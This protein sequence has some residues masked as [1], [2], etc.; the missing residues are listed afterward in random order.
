M[1]KGVQRVCWFAV[2]DQ[3]FPLS[4]TGSIEEEYRIIEQSICANT[5][6]FPHRG[7]SSY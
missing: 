2:T 6:T 7:L 4:G 3:V 5:D 1:P